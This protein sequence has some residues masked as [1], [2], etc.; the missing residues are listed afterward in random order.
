[1]REASAEEKDAISPQKWADRWTKRAIQH[2]FASR[3]A[4]KLFQIQEEHHV[5][6]LGGRVLDLGSAP[7]GWIQAACALVGSPRD[8]P[9]ARIVGVD[10]RSFPAP[11]AHWDRRVQVLH[12]SAEQINREEIHKALRILNTENQPTE[13]WNPLH[14]VLSDM[15]PP[16]TGMR[17]VDAQKATELAF[18]AADIALGYEREPQG[19][20]QT[21]GN[22]VIKIYDGQD[23]ENLR[24]RVRPHFQRTVWTR[25]ETTRPGS[26]EKYLVAL[27]RLLGQN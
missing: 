12:M 2:G 21:G 25:P 16:T 19:V 7:G 15:A 11:K 17:D 20:L 10:Q 26:R 4:Y 8:Q 27:Q 1:M 22:L 18:L 5:V 24:R 13:Q 9:Q 23:A 14:V 6:P 3:A